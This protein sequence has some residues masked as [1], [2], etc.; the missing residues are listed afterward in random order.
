MLEL[1]GIASKYRPKQITTNYS[2]ISIIKS[3]ISQS[4]SH[5]FLSSLWKKQQPPV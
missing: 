1:L 3:Q 5:M 2:I 4:H